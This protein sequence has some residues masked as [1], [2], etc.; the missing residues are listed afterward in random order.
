MVFQRSQ[1]HVLIHQ[2]PLISIGTVSNEINQILMVQQAQHQNL[3]K[4][5][6]V[7]LQSISVKLLHS[8][9]LN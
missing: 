4:K 3:H 8:Y 5:L 1:G 6:S 9:N 7:A 2:N